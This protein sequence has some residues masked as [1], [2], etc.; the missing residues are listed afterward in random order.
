MPAGHQLGHQGSPEHARHAM[1]CDIVL[2]GL[3]F[4]AV[5]RPYNYP[6]SLHIKMTAQVTCQHH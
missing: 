6:L 1:I 2:L 3:L 4:D 5:A